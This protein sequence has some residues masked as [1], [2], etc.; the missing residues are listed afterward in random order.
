MKTPVSAGFFD[1][2]TESL[3]D[4]LRIFRFRES[5]VTDRTQLACL[6]SALSSQPCILRHS[7]STVAGWLPATNPHLLFRVLVQIKDES[8]FLTFSSEFQAQ[9]WVS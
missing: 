7:S 3:D 1:T 5:V 8:H 4:F 6:V 9:A 2:I